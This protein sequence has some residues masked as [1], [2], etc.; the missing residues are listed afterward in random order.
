MADRRLPLGKPVVWGHA[1]SWLVHI[2]DGQGR[3]LWQSEWM[4]D[5]GPADELCKQ[6]RRAPCVQ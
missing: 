5:R 6:L 4:S 2:V 1:R 3:I